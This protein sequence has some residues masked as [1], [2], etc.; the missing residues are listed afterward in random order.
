MYNSLAIGIY[1]PFVLIAVVAFVLETIRIFKARDSFMLTFMSL[2]IV[3]WVTCEVFTLFI[4]DVSTNIYVWNLVPVFV[5]FASP[6]LFLF[7][8]W[9]FRTEDSISLRYMMPFFIIPMVNAVMALTSSH[10]MLFRY[11][12]YITIYPIHN[13]TY[14]LGP[15]FW[16]YVTYS[17]ALMMASVWII[18][19]GHFRKQKFYQLSST[20]MLIGIGAMLSGS[21]IS[22]MGFTPINLDPSA[23]AASV[24]LLF[25]HLA[26]S[27][28][29][30]SIYARYARSQVF[31]Y[32]EDYV[33][34]LGKNGEVSDFNPSASRWFSSIGID[35]R[36]YT[37][38]GILRTL[39]Q[40]GAAV[41]D[42][43]E[44][45][46]GC[47]IFFTEGEFPTVFNLR[48][49]DMTDEKNSKLGSIAF[50]VDVTQNRALLEQLEKKAGRD[51]I[52]GL[53]NRIAY[54][55]AR[56]RFDEPE[57]LP[58]SVI[59]CDVNGLKKANDTLG[60]KY[61]DMLLQV[62]SE[63]LESACP[64]SCFVARIGGDEFIYLLSRTGS[65]ESHALIAQIKETMKNQKGYPFKVSM[66]MGTATKH[67]PE[68]SLD[69]IIA[70][71]DSY[72]YEDK[73]LM[74]AK[75]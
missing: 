18:I 44:S 24:M 61:G 53:P 6:A 60:H 25:F 35:L 41:S 33:I 68:E 46:K 4:H 43:P 28:N 11:V 69:E 3:G 48:V 26:A 58:L 20:L 56:K 21:L 57:Y 71:A 13:I 29:D 63:I 45:Q 15:W 40:K 54:D 9:F 66:A 37:L 31:N 22:T 38:Q 17:Y 52:T 12:E 36:T 27:N 10:H 59:V 64:K 1:I 72:M 42:S 16:V 65:E 14:T 19:R 47:D 32:L 23:L 49:Y 62:I 74:K 7:V 5:G 75:R 34:V 67:S 51:S 70:M 39:I 73:K 50:F 30:H 55:G 8:H 2:C